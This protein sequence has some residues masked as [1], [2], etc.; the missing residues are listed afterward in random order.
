MC[1]S[2]LQQEQKWFNC[3]TTTPLIKHSFKHIEDV[4]AHTVYNKCFT[5][6][7]IRAFLTNINPKKL[8]G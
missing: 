6:H 5:F 1:L 8:R 7:V 3:S 2:F 4:L